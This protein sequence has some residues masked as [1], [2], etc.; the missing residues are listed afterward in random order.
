MLTFTDHLFAKLKCRK[1][2][3]KVKTFFHTW[4]ET[5]E[6]VFYVKLKNLKKERRFRELT[7]FIAN[8]YL[9]SHRSISNDISIVRNALR[10]DLHFFIHSI[11]FTFQLR[12]AFKNLVQTK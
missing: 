12:R 10:R 9:T 3:L 6:D 1:N 4:S 11:L 7:F 2:T 5:S 8:R